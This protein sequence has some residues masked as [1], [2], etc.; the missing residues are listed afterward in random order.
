MRGFLPLIMM[1]GVTF[2]AFGAEATTLL[3]LDISGGARAARTSRLAQ[4]KT[5]TPHPTPVAHIP[6]KTE[7][8]NF[9]NWAVTCQTFADAPKKQ[10]CRGQL[11]AEQS[12]S[13]R[14]ILIWTMYIGERK[15]LIGVIQ[16]LPGVTIAPGVEVDLDK[17]ND[18]GKKS[19]GSEWKFAYQSCESGG[20]RATRILD[21]KFVHD[22]AAA[23]A[24]TVVIQASN[25][26]MVR[27][28]FPI[29]GFG[30]TYAELRAKAG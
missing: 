27:I 20:C 3:P 22:A 7:T 6:E 14:I 25:G 24:A 12:G 2:G 26:E 8:T 28:N 30:K 9:E 13:R 5:S 17:G 10:S 29:K 11:R 21:S 18:K 15:Q 4:V 1:L 16:T 23:S 19:K